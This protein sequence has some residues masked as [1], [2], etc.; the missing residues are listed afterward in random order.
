MAIAHC[1][2]GTHAFEL[3][4]A[5]KAASDMR[6][7]IDLSNELSF[8]I[9]IRLKRHED[10]SLNLGAS[11]KPFILRSDEQ[12]SHR[13]EVILFVQRRATQAGHGN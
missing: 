7:R 3:N 11:V 9:G 6:H 12:L 13:K 4:C 10:R 1:L 8:A 5:A 2:R